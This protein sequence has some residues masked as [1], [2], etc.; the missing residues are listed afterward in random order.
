MNFKP[1]DVVTLKSG[2]PK[3]T[4]ERIDTFSFSNK[5]LIACTWFNGNVEKHRNFS[6]EV[7]KAVHPQ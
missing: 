2:G 4:I 1:G 3:M 7:L 6:P 5:P